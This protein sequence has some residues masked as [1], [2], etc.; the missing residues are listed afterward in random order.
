MGQTNSSEKNVLV[1][2]IFKLL[3]PLVRLMLRYG[4]SHDAFSEYAKRVYVDI[5]AEEYHLPGKRQSNARISVLTGLTRKEVTRIRTLSEDGE[6]D[7]L[8]TRVN[9]AVRVTSAWYRDPY[10]ANEKGQPARLA[11]SGKGPTFSQLVKKFSGDMPARTILDE[12]VRVGA[13]K[14]TSDGLIQLVARGYVPGKGN[15]TRIML[16]GED[17]VSLIET[18][19]HN[20]QSSKGER[21]YHKKVCY[22]NLPESVLPRLRLLAAQKGESVLVD[23]D[24]WLSDHDRDASPEKKHGKGRKRA[25][26]G[27][28]YFESDVDEE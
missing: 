10:Y 18:I 27:I 16:L 7:D 20:M 11:F 12:L 24:R 3:R 28:F 23:L 22:D 15:E 9:R 4:I 17:V 19:D 2:A 5:A 21:Y 8:D 26:L 13:V 14:I 25:G 6:S 1:S